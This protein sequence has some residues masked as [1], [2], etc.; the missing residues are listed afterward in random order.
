MVFADEIRKTILRLA[1]EA[2]LDKS[3]APADV[4]RAIDQKNWQLLLD[5]V[6]LVA[7][8]LI[9][10]GKITQARAVNPGESVHFKKL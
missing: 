6:K 3:F 7:D 4:A 9:K 8:S 5:Q 10:E 2:G 1:D